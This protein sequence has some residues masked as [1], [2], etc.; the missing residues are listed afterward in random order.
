MRS[1]A[2]KHEVGF[3]LVSDEDR[4]IVTAYGVLKEGESRRA[5]RSTVVIG[6]DG[7]IAASY[8]RVKAEGHAGEVLADLR[9]AARLASG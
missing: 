7:R 3:P 1:F 9:A 5:E 2:D 4:T 6:R 8:R